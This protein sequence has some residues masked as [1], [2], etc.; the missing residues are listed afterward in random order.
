M[1]MP[2]LNCADFILLF[3]FGGIIDE[4]KET[5]CETLQGMFE[6]IGGVPPRILFD[7]MSSAVVHIEEHGKRTITELFMRFTMHHRFQADFCNPDSPQEK[8]NVEN[9]VGYLRRN[10]LLPPPKIEDLASFNRDLLDKCMTDLNRDHY[11]IKEPIS[12]LFKAEENFFV[13]LPKERFRTFTLE[14][15]KTDD[16]SFIRY[17]N[18]FYSTKS[19]YTKCEMW[20]EVGANE[21]RILNN[22]RRSE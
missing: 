16:Y 10:Y 17:D 15:A 11:R 8:G 14:T 1:I 19:E 7:N 9:K 2:E 13:P 12:E 3:R 5:L 4:T 6:Y 20:L 22:N 18:N 21:I